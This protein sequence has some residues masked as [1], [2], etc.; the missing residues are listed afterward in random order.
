[1]GVAV[2]TTRN[3]RVLVGPWSDRRIVIHPFESRSAFR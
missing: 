3:Y 2:R 1:M